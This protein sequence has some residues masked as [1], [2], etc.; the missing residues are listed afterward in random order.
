MVRLEVSR[1]GR[2][3]SWKGHA[4]PYSSHNGVWLRSRAPIPRTVFLEWRVKL[5]V[6]QRMGIS[7]L[8]TSL[9]ILVILVVLVYFSIY[10]NKIGQ[11][12]GSKINYFIYRLFFLFLLLLAI[13]LKDCFLYCWIFLHLFLIKMNQFSFQ[14]FDDILLITCSNCSVVV[15]PPSPP[16]PFFYFFV[17][18][19][20]FCV[21]LRGAIKTLLHF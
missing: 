19:F 8:C 15:T 10:C 21:L 6:A 7:I 16:L 12:F 14:I 20:T 1:Y 11:T 13:W 17:C 9:S 18:V 5:P 2:T 3:S 4:V